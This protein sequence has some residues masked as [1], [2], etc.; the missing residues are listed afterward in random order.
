MQATF[1]PTRASI[2]EVDATTTEGVQ[3]WISAQMQL[4][5]SLH[6]AYYRERANP[7][8]FTK[9]PTGALRPAC[10]A[11]S[12]WHSFAFTRSDEGKQLAVSVLISSATRSGLALHIGGLLR[13]EVPATTNLTVGAT[14]LLC[15]VEERV[16]GPLLLVA[17]SDS[18]EDCTGPSVQ[19][20]DNPPIGFEAPDLS[21]THTLTDSDAVSLLTALAPEMRNVS[22]LARPLS[23]APW[24]RNATHVFLRV[25]AAYYRHDPRLQLLNNPLGTPADG[26]EA[27]GAALPRVAKTFLSRPSCLVLEG[28]A[29]A[30]ACGSPGEVANIPS[31]QNRYNIYH[32][33]P[34]CSSNMSCTRDSPGDSYPA[35]LAPFVPEECGVPEDDQ[36]NARRVEDYNY[37]RT[38]RVHAQLQQGK[39]IAWTMTAIYSNDQLRQRMAWGLYQIFVVSD[40]D[41]GRESQE[42][43]IWH[44][45]YDIFVR[46]A[47]G[48]FRDIMREVAYS[49][50]MATYLTFLKSKAMAHSGKYPDENFAREI[51]QLFTIGLWQ[52][53]D[54]GTQV[55]NEQ[56]APIMTSPTDDVVTLARAWTGFTRQAARTNLENRDGAADGGR[57]NVDPMNLRPDWRDIFPKL[58]LHGGYIGD[59]FPLCADLPAQLFLRPGARYTYHGP[60]LTEEMTRSFEGEGLPLID[61]SSSLYAELC[62][63]GGKSAGRCTF[64]S[65]VT[66]QTELACSGI[67]CMVDTTTVRLLKLVN[68]NSTTFFEW[69]R[70]AC[71]EM[72]VYSDAKR[73]FMSNNKD[74][75]MCA[76]PETAAAGSCCVSR[77]AGVLGMCRFA[78]E[79]MS[80]ATAKARCAAA[81]G[82]GGEVC[83]I[84][85]PANKRRYAVD[86]A[87]DP[88]GC[89]YVERRDSES[90]FF[91]I[92][93]WSSDS[94]TL[95][96]QVD[97][98]GWLLLVHSP[99]GHEYRRPSFA[100]DNGNYWRVAWDQHVYPLAAANCS[101]H[102]AVRG[103]TCMC[104]V[105]VEISQALTTIPSLATEVEAACQIGS[106]CPAGTEGDTTKLTLPTGTHELLQ[107]GAEVD[108]Y[109]D[110][111]NAYAGGFNVDALFRIKATGRCYLNKR[112][113]VLVG[114]AGATFSFRNGQ[115][116]LNLNPLPL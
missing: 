17:E 99:Y 116:R 32:S 42:V 81:P 28:G 83:H 73:I 56:G 62:W 108:V 84:T 50:L 111:S 60:K 16:G 53:Y 21:V 49:P 70:P 14:Y 57:N 39:N 7:R 107:A 93:M 31:R 71:V 33:L 92:R 74:F 104:D 85:N 96:V 36:R 68:G 63:G 87:T 46:N 115:H 26:S 27:Y 47:F 3:S 11:G 103:S 35:D 98:N 82:G 114:S 86:G 38:K 80:Y 100:A 77:G 8:A 29:G 78:A 55:L 105:V 94:C 48:S 112:S 51:M 4:Q 97:R 20:V 64:R 43:E 67:E 109:R 75:D 30:E 5:P 1:G 22:L 25:G 13:T 102:C 76:D 24:L 59:G 101:G 58:D 34:A 69:L 110:L 54:N 91:G 90:G 44:A 9:T 45:Y 10:E 40:K 15:R 65:Q 19:V 41:I 113:T 88:N 18:G 79:R 66:L 106:L 72:A 52:L 89:N 95:R 12:R 6:R 61:P 23:C 37:D 2:K